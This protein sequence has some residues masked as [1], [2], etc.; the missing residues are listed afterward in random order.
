MGQNRVCVSDST[1]GVHP[2]PEDF[3]QESRS[4]HPSLLLPPWPPLHSH[5][6]LSPLL[7]WEGDQ[8]SRFDCPGSWGDDESPSVCS[9]LGPSAV[10]CQRIMG[11]E[12]AS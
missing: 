11:I 2:F 6:D 7:A 5:L 8:L 10:A 3:P 9:H 1:S 12:V 4:V